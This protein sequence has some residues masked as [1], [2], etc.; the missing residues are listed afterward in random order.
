MAVTMIDIPFYKWFYN[1]HVLM[2]WNIVIVC[3]YNKFLMCKHT[4]PIKLILILILILKLVSV[5]AK[6]DIKCLR[7]NSCTSHFKVTR[8]VDLEEHGSASVSGR[9]VLIMSELCFSCVSLTFPSI[10][11][12]RCWRERTRISCC[13]VVAPS[14]EP[15]WE[16]FLT[17]VQICIKTISQTCRANRT[18]RRK[19]RIHITA[20]WRKS[21]KKSMQKGCL[22]LYE[23]KEWNKG[24]LS[25]KR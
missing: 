6:K 11:D 17:D 5:I 16:R 18:L 19:G 9:W 25:G 4:C 23:A 3:H 15:T 8:R 20:E 2:G 22:Q 10:W 12:Q 24:L 13:T 1:I 21:T 14:L 7:K